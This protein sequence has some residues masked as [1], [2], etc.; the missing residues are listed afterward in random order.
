[1][2]MIFFRD[3][4]FSGT[5]FFSPGAP[6]Y[7]CALTRGRAA[8]SSQYLH[9]R[10]ASVARIIAPSTENKR[11]ASVT[12]QCIIGAGLHITRTVHSQRQKEKRSPRNSWRALRLSTRVATVYISLLHS[13][14]GKIARMARLQIGRWHNELAS[15]IHARIK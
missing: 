2:V 14:F 5:L 8:P 3:P 11:R 6:V 9:L 7:A 4:L 10:G 15:C 12:T 13:C 1:M